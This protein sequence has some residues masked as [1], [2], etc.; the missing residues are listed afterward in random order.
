MKEFT[1]SIILSLGG[2]LIVPNGS[3]DISFLQ[4]FN[5]FVRRQVETKGR[6]FFIITGGGG[7]A[8]SYIEGATSIIENV[9]HS[10]LDWLGIHSTRL[11]AHLVR[12]IFRDIARPLI[13]EHY[14]DVQNIREYPVIIGSGWKPGWSTDYCAVS[15]AKNYGG[16]TVINMSNTDGVYTADPRKDPHATRYDRIS[17]NDYR[18]MVG[19]TWV[20]GL[21]APIDPIAA[22]LASDMSLTIITLEGKDLK[23]LEN[24]IEKRPFVGT[25]IAK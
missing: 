21:S 22:R 2:S 17:W 5:T 9:P 4:Q 25:T 8:R 10:D 1:E 23:N 11:N 14:D 6:R 12:T 24:A 20:P 18:K 19:D 13:I 16:T 15:M 7:T 3:I